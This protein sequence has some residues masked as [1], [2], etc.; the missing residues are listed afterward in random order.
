METFKTAMIDIGSNTIR[1]VLYSFS[2]EK[3][4]NEFGNFKRVAR[5]RK[6]I[7]PDGSMSE[8]GIEILK[9]TL[10]SFKEISEDYRVENIKAVATAAIRQANNNQEILERMENETGIQI[11]LLSEEEEAYFGYL[12]VVHSMEIPSAVTVDIGGGSTEVT[13]F[14]NKELKHSISFPFGTI[15]LKQ[16]FVSGDKINEKEKKKLTQYIKEQFEK[17]NWLKGAG[18]PIVGIGG[19]ARNIAQMHQHLTNYPISGIHHYEMNRQALKKLNSYLGKRSIEQLRK[20]EGLSSDR[21]DIIEIALDVFRTLMEIVDA[22][23]FCVSKSGLRDGV[24]L[25]MMMKSYPDAFQSDTVYGKCKHLAVKYGRTEE[26]LDALV[27]LTENF[28]LECCNCKLLKYNDRQLQLIKKAASV[29]SI[30]DYIEIDSSSQHTFYIIANQSI[31]GLSHKNRIKIALLASYKNKEY[32]RR[33]SRPFLSWFSREELKILQKLGGI[34]KFVYSLNAS[35]RNVVKRLKMNVEKDAI[36][37][38][39]VAKHRAM[40]EFYRAELQKKHI[41]RLFKRNVQIE[42]Y[43]EGWNSDG[44]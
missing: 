9:Q 20:M 1:L 36:I 3:G 41:E 32:F 28:Y 6:Y 15:S 26:E 4:L 18:L 39:I 25:D 30:G 44:N 43:I 27:K 8:Q 23:S 14:C 22:D 31:P 29:F 37:L 21:A 24:M 10:V 2:K 5:L 12:A 42:W 33:F 11:D 35:K 34:L 17:I 16:L 38:S 19:S 40:A 7:Q 13:L